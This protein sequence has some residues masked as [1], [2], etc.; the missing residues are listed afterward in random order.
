MH[1]PELR[2]DRTDLGAR[3]LKQ[4]PDLLA[5]FRRQIEAGASAWPQL[6]LQRARPGPLPPA[7][8]AFLQ[9]HYNKDL[10]AEYLD[11]FFGP[12]ALTHIWT[13]DGDI[14][15]LIGGIVETIAVC[16]LSAPRLVVNF[17][18]VAPELRGQGLVRY[19]DSALS[20][21]A[22]ERDLESDAAGALVGA[23]ALAA[24]A[25]KASVLSVYHTS[26]ALAGGFSTTTSYTY[27]VQLEALRRVGAWGGARPPAVP[28][29]GAPT[30]VLAGALDDT[31]IAEWVARH[32]AFHE[33]NGYAA[34]RDWTAAEA[35]RWLAHP[36]VVHLSIGED[37]ICFVMTNAGRVRVAAI[38]SCCFADAAAAE[39]ALAAAEHWLRKNSDAELAWLL[40]GLPTAPASWKKV[41]KEPLN[42]FLVNQLVRGVPAAANSLT[43]L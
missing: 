43:M 20:L 38:H 37:D 30:R 14:V 9:Q 11:I 29:R 16:G 33:R 21:E 5:A 23:D 7:A 27:P 26:T 24:T 28:A 25:P 35:M 4:L 36:A 15:A 12:T 19:I 8:V 18:C 32:K 2:L 17:L 39:G 3:Y 42:H 31:Y 13:R 10:T 40:V 41:T 1:R 22:C 6:E 34:Y